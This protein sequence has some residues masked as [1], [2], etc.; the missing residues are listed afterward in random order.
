MP[1]NIELNNRFQPK[2]I[3]KNRH[4]QTLYAKFFREQEEPTVH[5]EIFE[6]EDGDFLEC[7]WHN[8]EV[9][10]EDAPI[11]VLFHG[12]EGSYKSPYIEGMMH[13][14]KKEGFA[15]VLMHF[16]GCGDEM[17]R[18][19]RAYHSGETEDAKSYLRALQARYVKSKLFCV[20][21]SLGGNMLLKLLSEID[22]SLKIE[23]A[24][25]VSAPMQL[26][27]CAN[28]M[29]RGFSKVYQA[30]LMKNLK[31]SLIKKYA[32]HD[33]KTLLDVSQNEVEDMVDFWEFDG[34]Y[35]ARIH[36]FDSAQDYYT[37]CSSRQ[38]LKDIKT[39]TL[40]IHALDDP[41]MTPEILP[42]LDELSSSVELEVYAHGG[43]VGFVAGSFRK[44]EY[45]LDIR[46]VEYLKKSLIS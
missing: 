32:Q 35:T 43:H 5:K 20:G 22:E 8:Q 44:P 17:N 13:A 4:V 21:F 37:K 26:D 39:P 23:A 30:H 11:L 33:M 40:I 31:E 1:H 42:H 27:I 3:L 6:L 2:G 9:L 18:L 25:S 12:L 36:G 28:Q 34:A 10:L 41:F 38:F 24:V 46:L 16:R 45:W 7:F 29:K 19:P 14:F 15:V